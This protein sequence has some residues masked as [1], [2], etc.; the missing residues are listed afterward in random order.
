MGSNA[1]A[2]PESIALPGD[3]VFSENITSTK[4]G[5]L[6]VGSLGAGGILRIKPG[7]ARAELWIKPGA[8]GSRSIFG[9]LADQR[10]NALWACS[11][12]LSALGVV[13]A[14]A[15]NGSALKGFDL[16]TWQGKVSAR[17]PSGTRR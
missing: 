17:L 15:E 1:F 10:S 2:A 4:D 11:N 3:R 6:Y 9:V 8:F 7:A 16:K 5:T 13:I 14:S 12:D